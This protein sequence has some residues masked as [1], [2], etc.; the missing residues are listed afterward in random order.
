MTITKLTDKQKAQ[1]CAWLDSKQIEQDWA[2]RRYGVTP[3]H[4]STMYADYNAKKK[5]KNSL[6]KR[7]NTAIP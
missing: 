2:A 4:I 7:P 3:Q 1:C 6:D 5:Q